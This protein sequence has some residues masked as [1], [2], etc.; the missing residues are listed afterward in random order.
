MWAALEGSDGAAHQAER[1]TTWLGIGG[2]VTRVGLAALATYTIVSRLPRLQDHIRQ[3][4]EG[5]F[6]H[7][8]QVACKRLRDLVEGSARSMATKLQ[9]LNVSIWPHD[10]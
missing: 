3:I 2:R 1:L 8:I 10:A 9:A 5:E 4:G 6:K 7:R